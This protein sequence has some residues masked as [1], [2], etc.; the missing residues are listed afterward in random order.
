MFLDFF[1]E[2]TVMGIFSGFHIALE[3]SSGIPFKKKQAIRQAITENDGIVSY[4]LTKKVITDSTLEG[5]GFDMC[6]SP[7]DQIRD[8]YFDPLPLPPEPALLNVHTVH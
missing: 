5:V 2:I 8:N 7:C 1:P 4:I 6:K 3:L